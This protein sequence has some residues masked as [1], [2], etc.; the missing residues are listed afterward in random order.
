MLREILAEFF[1][2]RTSELSGVENG[3]YILADE[4]LSLVK[5]NNKK[6]LVADDEPL[7]RKLLNEFLTLV[8]L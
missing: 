5:T 8:R 6:I 4:T 3:N 1:Y 7:V 2:T